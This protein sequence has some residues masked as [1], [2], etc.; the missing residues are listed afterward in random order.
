MPYLVD[1]NNLLGAARDARLGLPRD[2]AELLRRLDRFA[3]ARR[4]EILVVFDGP[5][6]TGR[7]AGQAGRVGRARVR[8]AG[9]GRQADDLIVE[10]IVGWNNP[11]E[12][13]LVSSDNQLRGRAKATGARVM[14]CAE[15]AGR[16]R[17]A[18][19]GLTNGE[20]DKPLVGDIAE[21][22]EYFRRGR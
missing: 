12:I 21:W 18:A 22:E 13:T 8:Y 6:G 9:S 14:G 20:D 16:L 4:S 7:A 11:A 1:G 10:M 5:A 2:E 19:E 15:F 3:Q 17:A